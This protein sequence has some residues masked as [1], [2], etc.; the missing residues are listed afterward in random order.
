MNKSSFLL[1]LVL[2]GLAVAPAPAAEP[3][4][5]RVLSYNIHHGEGMD[6]KLDLERIARVILSADPHVVSLQE[7]DRGVK[8]SG[9]VDEPAELARLTKMTAIFERNIAVQGGEY[10]NAVLTRLPVSA[11]RNVP[12]PS[13]DGGEQRG[14]LVVDLAAPG[15]RKSPFRFLATHLDHR[16]SDA[17]RLDS[18]K[19]IEEIVRETPDHPAVLAG[20]LNTPSEG[21]VLR[22]FGADWLRSDLT[23]LPT[24]P[25]DAPAR[26]IDHVLAR[27]AARWNLLETRVLDEPVASDH[28]P[29]LVVLELVE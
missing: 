2:A 17:E 27:P 4:R 20:D 23:P 10:G 13:H 5:I 22:A 28:R 21:R 6:G 11:R 3:T 12:L 9:G 15:D 16:R 8:R 26:R 1:A 29:L 19:R 14:V 24:F 18:V 7:V 25:A